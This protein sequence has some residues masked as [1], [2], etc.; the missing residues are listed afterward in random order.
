M[1]D[2]LS[3]D[4]SVTSVQLASIFTTSAVLEDPLAS[5]SRSKA[6]VEV[7]RRQSSKLKSKSK[8]MLSTEK[9]TKKQVGNPIW[10]VVGH[11]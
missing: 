2:D 6:R 5:T 1:M 7:K 4:G 8:A 11:W 3:D 10:C 9:G